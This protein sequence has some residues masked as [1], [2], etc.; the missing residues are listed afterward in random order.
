MD[1]K[2]PYQDPSLL[3][4]DKPQGLATG[5]GEQENLCELL[6]KQQPFLA[7]VRGYKKGEGGLL[8]RLDNE[9]GGLMLFAKTDEAFKYYAKQM[10]EGR[11]VKKYLAV[12]EGEIKGSHGVINVQIAH[13]SKNAQK[14]VAGSGPHR[15]QW[16]PAETK[17]KVVKRDNGKSVL[18]I[19]ITKGV[20][21]QI[22][23]HL[24][25]I[26]YPVVADKLYNKKKYADIKYHKLYAYGLM[27]RNTM[28][29]VIRVNLPINYVII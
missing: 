7:K 25:S 5:L 19:E 8:N 17:W 1:F 21:H 24:A 9:T 15:S 12:V 10:S 23:V 28:N 4:V 27:F 26:G 11:I 20:R 22:R 3:I 2:I 29:R 6:F 18:E 14:M 16:Q 13:H